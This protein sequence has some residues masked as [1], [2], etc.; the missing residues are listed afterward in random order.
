[1]RLCR[2]A[3]QRRGEHRG[4]AG[5]LCGHGEPSYRT[6]LSHTL[7]RISSNSCCPITHTVFKHP[8]STLQASPRVFKPIPIPPWSDREPYA[9]WG[10]IAFAQ[11]LNMGRICQHCDAPFVDSPYRV[12]SEES[13]IVLLDLIVCHRCHE[14]AQKLGLRTEEIKG[15]APSERLPGH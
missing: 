3:Q 9:G 1:M 15:S 2:T 12:I 14:Q 7:L 6:A 5:D 13:G 4:L 8:L 10:G 11:P